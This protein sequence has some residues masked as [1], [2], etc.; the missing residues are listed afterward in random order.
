MSMTRTSAA[1]LRARAAMLARRDE[2]AT[3]DGLSLIEMIVALLL[4]S[5]ILISFVGVSIAGV[6]SSRAA[7][8]RSRANE[9]G[10]QEVE[11]F[12][13]IPWL[14]LGLYDNDTTAAGASPSS[15]CGSES[16][17]SLGASAPTPR[18][19]PAFYRVTNINGRN[20]TIT[21]C[22]TWRD[23]PADGTVAAGNEADTDNGQDVKHLV[24][25]VSWTL[26]GKT[27]T[28]TFDSLRSPTAAEVPPVSHSTA[29]LVLTATAPS[30]ASQQ[31][32]ADSTLTS[33]LTLGATTSLTA[34]GVTVTYTGQSGP[35][36]QNLS[37]SDGGSTWTITIPAGLSG[38]K[39][40]AGTLALTYKATSGSGNAQA[41]SSVSLT[42]PPTPFTVTASAN[43]TSVFLDSN[44]YLTASL[45]INVTTSQP[46][47]AVSMS[48]PQTSSTGSRTLVNVS[49]GTTWQVVLASG[50]GSGQFTATS[51]ELFTISATNASGTVT[52]T[53]TA[54][55]APPTQAAI[56]YVSSAVSPYTQFCTDKNGGD[57]TF[58]DQTVSITVDNMV[59]SDS[60]TLSWTTRATST[61]TLIS[62]SA[63]VASTTAVSSTRTTYSFT[64]PSGSQMYTTN[65]FTFVG[66]RASD[67]SGI[68]K[69]ITFSLESPTKQSQC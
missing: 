28:I 45:T 55:L 53:T 27:R 34:T 39:F 9:V 62:G 20:Y 33:P 26:L 1:V 52:G 5:M 64:V 58:V 4:V 22:I 32:A 63:T 18:V 29:T 65:S 16:V 69:V 15:T 23:D 17:V 42:A 30:P 50:A 7:E 66:K 60:M 41:T 3:E 24:T 44:G 47:T 67:G 13:S 10:N 46:A 68:N 36:T 57:Q 12:K 35:V 11:T 56:A 19:A 54:T 38:G 25:T 59:P 37:S 21:N 43:P 2:V 49:G 61:S 51:A 40:N 14:S 48:F 6:T 31:L 8:A